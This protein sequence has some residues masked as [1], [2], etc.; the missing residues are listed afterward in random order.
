MNKRIIAIGGGE[1]KNRETLEIDRFIAQEA[2]KAAGDRRACGLFIPAAEGSSVAVFDDVFCDIGDSQSIEESLST[3]SSHMA[4][5]I[6]ICQK[7]FNLFFIITNIPS[8]KIWKRISIL[9]SI[10]H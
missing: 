1:I 2:T 6:K 5:I 3:F 4:N 10:F 8:N 7:Y 9:L